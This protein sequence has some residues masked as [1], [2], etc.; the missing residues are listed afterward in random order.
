MKNVKLADLY[1]IKSQ[2]GT[3]YREKCQIGRFLCEKKTVEIGRSI[4]YEILNW[5]I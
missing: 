3:F 1:R 4:T 5:H 2:I